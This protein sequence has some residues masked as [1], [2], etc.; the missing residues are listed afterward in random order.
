[1]LFIPEGQMGEV[2]ELS[3]Q[4]FSGGNWGALDRHISFFL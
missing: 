3:K 4:L 1:M 2:Y